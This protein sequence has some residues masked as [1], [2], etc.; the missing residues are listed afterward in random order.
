MPGTGQRAQDKTFSS[1]PFHGHTAFLPSHSRFS[2][3][4]S[5]NPKKE[6]KADCK[7]ITLVRP[8]YKTNGN[9]TSGQR[10]FCTYHRSLNCF[11]SNFQLVRTRCIKRTVD[12]KLV[13]LAT[14]DI[15]CQQKIVKVERDTCRNLKGYGRGA[16]KNQKMSKP[17]FSRA[18][19]SK[20]LFPDQSIHANRDHNNTTCN[21]THANWKRLGKTVVTSPLNESRKVAGH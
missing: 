21:A 4:S 8:L 20:S 5:S 3:I 18:H 9:M 1:Q 17:V 2:A 19:S 6:E 11:I 16:A 12:L 14:D 10:V 7:Q 13:H 15:L